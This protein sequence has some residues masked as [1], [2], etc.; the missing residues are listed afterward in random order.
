VSDL[1]EL[2]RRNY[3]QVQ[4]PSMLRFVVDTRG[5][6]IDDQQLRDDFTTMLVSGHGTAAAVLTLAIIELVKHPEQMKRVQDKSTAFF[7]ITI[8]L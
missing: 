3:D 2:E 1:E 8:A 5:A 7:G 6:N 4:D